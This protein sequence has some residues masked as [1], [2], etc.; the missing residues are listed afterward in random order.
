MGVHL[1]SIH[2]ISKLILF[3]FILFYFGIFFQIQEP[4]IP[5]RKGSLIPCAH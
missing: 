5:V 4:S 3:Y 1:I 2:Q